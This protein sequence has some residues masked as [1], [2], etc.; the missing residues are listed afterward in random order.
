[1]IELMGTNNRLVND[2]DVS[3]TTPEEFMEIL[4][5]FLRDNY[6]MEIYQNIPRAGERNRYWINIIRKR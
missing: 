4:I 1:M 6:E 2:F 3:F 5:T